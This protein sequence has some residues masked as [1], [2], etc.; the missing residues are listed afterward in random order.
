MRSPH[1]NPMFAR[2]LTLHV[3]IGCL[4]AA[5]CQREADTLD[6]FA[7][8]GE[9]PVLHPARSTIPAQFTETRIAETFVQATHM[10]VAPDGRLFVAEQP[11]VVRVVKNDALL[12]TPF[13]TID[14]LTI[15]AGG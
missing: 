4:V 11:G 6:P 10:V 9:Q 7:S 12:S 15:E 3:V 8:Q 2:S 13:A 14:P 1:L 5:G